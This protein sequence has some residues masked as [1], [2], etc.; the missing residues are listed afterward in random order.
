MGRNILDYSYKQCFKK[1]QST[2][3]I[4][5]TLTFTTHSSFLP[6]LP[7]WKEKSEA[8]W[9]TCVYSI[10]V[11]KTKKRVAIIQMFEIAKSRARRMVI[12]N[13]GKKFQF[14]KVFVYRSWLFFLIPSP[15]FQLL[16]ITFVFCCFFLKFCCCCCLLPS[17]GWAW[18]EDPLCW[19]VAG[20]C[21]GRQHGRYRKACVWV[22]WS[23]FPTDL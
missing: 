14:S 15:I 4:C 2:Q 5:F 21:R 13:R 23:A 10:Y 3:K 20:T 6:I 7:F 9:L 12:V 8:K 16:S 11:D 17:M 18:V 1:H 19:A 22:L